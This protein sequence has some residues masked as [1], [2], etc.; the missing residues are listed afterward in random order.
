MR[1]EDA[2]GTTTEYGWDL[3]D[4]LSEVR[5]HGKVRERYV[6]DAAGGLIEK[7]VPRIGSPSDAASDAPTSDG[8]GSAADSD[9][10][11]VSYVRGP[12]RTLLGRKTHADGFGVDGFKRLYAFSHFGPIYRIVQR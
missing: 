3:R 8:A 6:Y 11:L 10:L 1:V 12:L 5:R 7:R 9:E 2:L 4:R